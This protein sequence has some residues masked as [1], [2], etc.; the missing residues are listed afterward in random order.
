MVMVHL[1]I[2]DCVSKNSCSIVSAT[3][4]SWPTTHDGERVG[5]VARCLA[6]GLNESREELPR[7]MLP[8][9]PCMKET[10]DARLREI[11]EPAQTFFR[12]RIANVSVA[13]RPY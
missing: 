7:P 5:L 11:P 6:A 3:K 1:P 4:P 13:P 12:R 2:I 8:M 10:G 9:G